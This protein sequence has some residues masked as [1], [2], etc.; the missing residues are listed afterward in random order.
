MRNH[1]I[2][3]GYGT[4]GRSAVDA[5]LGD[6][7]PTDEIV[8][9]DIEH[10]ALDR[11]AAAGLVTVLGNATRSGCVAIGR[12]PARLI[13]C[14]GDQPLRHRGVGHLDRS[15]NCPK[16]R[17]VASVCEAENRHLL[18]QSGADSVV[19]SAETAGRLLGIAT[20]TPTVVKIMEDLLTP[21][22]GFAIA[23]REVEPTEVGESARHSSEVVVALVRNG[24]LL[25]VDASD[26]E[27]IRAGDRLVYIRDTRGRR[28]GAHVPRSG[29]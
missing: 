19:V 21:K 9:V 15:G 28:G 14:F 20:E 27:A 1:T 16:A 23:E 7:V 2:V 11:A 4:K 10:A 22:A 8:V 25:H 3:I 6:G 13:D 24:E 26:A 17:I 18:R 12:R 29:Q 5:M